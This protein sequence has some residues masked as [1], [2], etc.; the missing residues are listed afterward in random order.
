[1][2]DFIVP[3][4]VAAAAKRKRVSHP[5]DVTEKA[6]IEA[7]HSGVAATVHK[8]NKDLPQD[9]QLTMAAVDNWLRR[10]KREGAFWEVE[11]KRGR[12]NVLEQ[13]DGA[14]A[15]WQKQIESLRKQGQ[16]VTSRVSA[17]VVKAVLEEK[18]PRML[19]GHGGTFSSSISSGM[20]LLAKDDQSYRKKSSSRILPP[21][22]DLSKERDSFFSRVRD[23]FPGQ[24]LDE[25]LIINFDQTMQSYNPVRGFTW[26]KKGAKRVQVVES[27]E[28]FTLLPVVSAGGVIGAQLIFSGSTAASLPAVPPGPLLRYAQTENHWSN[29]NTTI[30]L[31]RSIILPHIASRRAQLRDVAAPAIIFAD[32]FPPHWTPAVQNLVAQ[33]DAVAYVAIPKSL[34]HL[35]QP[36]DLGIIAAIKQS[37]LRRKDDHM[38]AEVRAAIQQGMGVSIV[39]SRP[40][41]R[42]NVTQ[43]IKDCIADPALCGC[44]CCRAGFERAGILQVLL[45]GTFR[46][47]DIDSLVPPAVCQECGELAVQRADLPTCS[48]FA[49]VDSAYLCDGC[50]D[51]HNNICE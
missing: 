6:V 40:L 8:L 51:N 28:G 48:C 17:T 38:E 15:E 13:V 10:W 50:F 42:N 43:W 32:A 5:A 41:L 11:R 36:L 37:I 14:H 49:A 12:K 46:A 29:E 2:D 20:R 16:P 21:E 25:H 34:T 9:K 30:S 27:K 22:D 18:A 23:C 47:P 39:S 19:A 24:E 4:A 35:F 31:F 44:R 7:R 45:P 33:Q 3:G 1:M 26:E